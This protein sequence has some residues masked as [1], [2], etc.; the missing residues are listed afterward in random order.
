LKVVVVV[1]LVALLQT[2]QLWAQ[3]AL[4]HHL[5]LLELP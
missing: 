1:V 3:V 5:A 2:H 4:E